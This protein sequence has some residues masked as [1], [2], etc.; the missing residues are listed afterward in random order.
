MESAATAL[1]FCSRREVRPGT[2]A[3]MGTFHGAFRTRASVDLSHLASNRLDF[4]KFEEILLQEDK[5]A[6]GLPYSLRR[7][8]GAESIPYLVR[9][10]QEASS[11]WVRLACARELRLEDHPE[12][13]R[14]FRDATQ[15]NKRYKNEVLGLVRG[16][17]KE[18]A[19]PSEADI[20]KVLNEKAGDGSKATSIKEE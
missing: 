11:E 3:A 1:S 10:I 20:L 5:P 13:F 18:A 2:R 9:A 6:C 4:P 17:V 19:N 15:H 8:Y 14:F 12:A 16:Y 7:A